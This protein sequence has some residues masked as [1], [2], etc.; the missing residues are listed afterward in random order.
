MFYWH[1]SY[2]FGIEQSLGILCIRVPVFNLH[3]L[4]SHEFCMDFRL[5]IIKSFNVQFFLRKE[6]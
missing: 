4:R 5:I 6:E 3:L 2:L 1:M